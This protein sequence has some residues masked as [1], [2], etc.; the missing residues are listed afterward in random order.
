M[1]KRILLL[2]I[3]FVTLLSSHGQL[4]A[5]HQDVHKKMTINTI[6][7]MT[8]RLNTYFNDYIGETDYLK[9]LIWRKSMR[10]WIEDGSWWEDLTVG[11]YTD[12]LTSHYYNP[13]TNKG[14]T[15]AGITLGV[16]AYDRANDPNNFYSWKNARQYFYQGLT[17][18]IEAGRDLSLANSFEILG[19][20]VHLIQDMSVPAHTRDDMHIPYVD[21]EPYEAYTKNN[22]TDLDYTSEPFPYWNVS[23]SPGAPKQFW[24]LDSYNGTVAYDSGYIGLSEYTHANFLSKD[25]IFKDFAHPARENTNYYEFGLLPVTVITTPGNINHNTFYITGYGKERLAA[26]KYLAGELWDLP[27]PLPRLYQLTLHLDKRCHQEYAQY[28]VPRAVGYSAGLLDYFFRGKLQVTAVPIFYKNAIEY[29]RVRIKNLTP[30]GETM[31][32]GHFTLTYSYRPTGGKPDGSQDIWD[33]APVVPSGTLQYGGDDQNPVEDTIIDFWL[34]T[35]IPRENYDSAK[36]ALAFKGKLG[37]EEGAV[38]GKAL[39]LGEIKFEEE[40]DNGL[41]GNHTWAHIDAGTSQAYPDHGMTSNAIVGDT[42][43]KDNIRYV[44]YRNPSVN[45]S[46]VDV[47]Y[48]N[49]QFRDILPI[50][51]TPNTYLEF[52]ID[53]MSI[54]QIPPAP[55][56]KTSHWQTLMLYFNNGLSI[57]Y[58]Q[59]GQGVIFGPKTVYLTFPLGQ[60]IVDNIYERFQQAGITIPNEPLKL[61]G[62]SFVQQL[63]DLEQPSSV[64]HHQHMEIDSIRII[65]GKQ[66]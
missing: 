41:T 7:Q 34:P 6:N 49:G 40:W 53:K 44:N 16:S 29:L 18:T 1:K 30:T 56:G 66:Q 19:H 13:Y 9:K 15:E 48:N 50:L 35:P 21:G 57:Q 62:I 11:F 28:L 51:I 63:L 5:Y 58:F 61:G 52:K 60:I 43:V 45:Q 59:E 22:S 54:N 26:L 65:E 47:G 8:N 24:D 36:F 37:N 14:L 38:I 10:T 31:K 2:I 17:S 55:P 20:V 42:L 23:V 33:Q 46:L 25:T 4:A 12:L 39:T 3:S 27:I 32:D 64:E